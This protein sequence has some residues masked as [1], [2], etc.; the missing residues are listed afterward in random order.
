MQQIEFMAWRLRTRN[1]V[2]RA[3]DPRQREL[4]RFANVRSLHLR[5]LDIAGTTYASAVIPRRGLLMEKQN[6]NG[7]P[8]GLPLVARATEWTKEEFKFFNAT[9]RVGPPGAKGKSQNQNLPMKEK[10]DTDHALQCLPLV[11]VRTSE[12]LRKEPRRSAPLLTRFHDHPVLESKP[13]FRIIL[14]LENAVQVTWRRPG[15]PIE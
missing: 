8:Q 5:S 6:T 13:H 14:R 10:Q 3:A 4:L 7:A 9:Y 11:G 2:T 12:T 1:P 15:L